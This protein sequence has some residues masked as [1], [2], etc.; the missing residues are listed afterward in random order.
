MADP[1]ALTVPQKLVR[2]AAAL[3]QPF[4]AND[5]TVAAWKSDSR[6]FGLKGYEALHPDS[7]AVLAS[8]MGEKGLVRRGHFERVGPKLYRLAPAGAMAAKHEERQALPAPKWP[9]DLDTELCRLLGTLAYRRHADGADI[10]T[11]A[12]WRF[13]DCEREDGEAVLA[14]SMESVAMTIRDAAE[15]VAAGL[16]LGCGRVVKGEELETLKSCDEHLQAQF[17]RRRGMRRVG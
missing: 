10:P 3:P 5:L 15:Y 4:T 12:A 14:L 6:T 1:T 17:A 2:V 16:A 11:D 9:A 7:N 8:L 13:Y